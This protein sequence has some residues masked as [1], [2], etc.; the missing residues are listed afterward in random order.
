MH[1]GVEACASVWRGLSLCLVT[2]ND[3]E[4]TEVVTVI[5]TVMILMM[6]S[7]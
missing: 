7:Q 3:V 1:Q 4:D 5:T 2:V 6:V